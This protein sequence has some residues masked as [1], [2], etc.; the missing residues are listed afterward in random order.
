MLKIKQITIILL[1]LIWSITALSSC[2]RIDRGNETDT[3]GTT[4][5]GI[6]STS[7]IETEAPTESET[8]ESE[9]ITGD[10]NKLQ[11]PVVSVSDENGYVELVYDE[12][13]LPSTIRL[14]SL[15]RYGEEIAAQLQLKNIAKLNFRL[16]S[17]YRYDEANEIDE[18]K[19]AI[20]V[21]GL[22]KRTDGTESIS[23][24]VAHTALNPNMGASAATQP[25][26]SL[27]NFNIQLQDYVIGEGEH[28]H[29]NYQYYT[30]YRD[31][32]IQMNREIRLSKYK[33]DYV[34]GYV[35]GRF[36]IPKTDINSFPEL[37][38]SNAVECGVAEQLEEEFKLGLPVCDHSGENWMCIQEASCTSYSRWQ[39]NCLHCGLGMVKTIEEFKHSFTDAVC[40]ECGLHENASTN[41]DFLFRGDHYVIR[42]PGREE[43]TA[44]EIILPTVYA[45]LPVTRIEGAFINN[46]NVKRVIIPEGYTE[47][48]DQTFNGC[49]ALESVIIPESVTEI[50][51]LAFSG[52]GSLKSIDLHD[53]ITSIGENAFRACGLESFT[54][55]ASLETVSVMLMQGC[56]SMKSLIIPKPV[57]RVDSRAFSN[58]NNLK[59]VLFE[60]D[61]TAISSF[62]FM[63]CINLESITLPSA[64]T[65]LDY[66]LFTDCVKLKSI[67]LP[68]KLE[69]IS[70]GLFKNC[71]S[72][73]SLTI[74]QSVTAIEAT[75]FEGCTALTELTL[76]DGLLSLQYSTFDHC[77][78][79]KELIIP[80]G[81]KYVETFLLH[82]CI[83]LE[84]V[85][86]GSGATKIMQEAFTGCSTLK[87]VT[88]PESVTEI[89]STAFTGCGSL[90][91]IHFGGTAAQWK[92]IAPVA[93][94]QN[95][96]ESY[97]VHC[98]DGD[99]IFPTE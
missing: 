33:I 83:A 13:N 25:F 55:P 45:G 86:I 58:M 65:K 56:N 20:A 94:T 31:L 81:V 17:Y 52:C 90:D 92:R 47:I 72:L 64:L 84:R 87:E 42:G 1:I 95:F 38:T 89:H 24:Y 76:P 61:E 27:S 51:K 36:E 39:G 16:Y 57:K 75:A 6:I 71:V 67:T 48:G 14:V 22:F 12:N 96:A 77:T 53:G 8:K 4:D 29:A 60:G 59:Q 40:T 80:D 66:N 78:A 85:V 74:P 73:S 98:V 93:V 79:L 62:A 26:Y 30:F 5:Q 68:E 7:E 46:K 10:D 70:S 44:E 21:E 63:G 35:D 19:F 15:N 99:I 54:F 32:E 34:M 11:Y 28:S 37:P 97:T 2:E 18:R 82:N 23:A 69:T 9:P 49:A 91:T 43:E 88:I 41:F 50:G 3:E